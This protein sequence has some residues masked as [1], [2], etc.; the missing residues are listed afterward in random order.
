MIRIAAI[1]FAILGFSAAVFAAPPKVVKATPDNAATDVDPKLKQIEIVFDQPMNQGGRSIVGGG[2][3]FP[4]ITGQPKWTNDRTIVI[5]VELEADHDYRLSINN[6][7]FTNFKNPKGKSAVP[8]PISFSTGG[9]VKVSPE[10]TH[11]A[12]EQLR[13]AIDENYSYRDLRKIDWDKLFKEN[14]P[15][16]EKCDTAKAFTHRR[17]SARGREGHP[18]IPEGRRFV[19][20][21][22]QAFG[23]RQHQS[24]AP[25]QARRTIQREPARRD[26]PV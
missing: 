6:Q 20:S 9:A 3:T 4:K 24:A 2:P 12:I 14:G 15:K 8:Y 23:A 10:V 7:S 25:A 19:V 11:K 26:G 17:A 18:S 13:R 21:V 5:P 16:L 22:I 1:G